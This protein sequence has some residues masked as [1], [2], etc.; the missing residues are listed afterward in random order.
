[1]I[2]NK[3]LA[4]FLMI[5]LL[6]SFIGVSS[7]SAEEPALL[8][9]MDLSK[10]EKGAAGESWGIKNKGVA[11][12]TLVIKANDG[13][14]DA[15][16]QTGTITKESYTNAKGKTVDYLLFDQQ[17]T[18]SG[19]YT[20][21]PN[22]N[23]R[24]WIEDTAWAERE[25]TAEVWMKANTPANENASALFRVFGDEAD[26]NDDRSTFSNAYYTALRAKT[27]S[28]MILAI[29]PYSVNGQT[30][31]TTNT[32]TF[33]NGEW[34]HITIK[35]E[36]HSKGNLQPTILVNGE[37]L[38]NT[39]YYAKDKVEV[40]SGLFFGETSNTSVKGSPDDMGIASIKIYDGILT[41]TQIKEHYDEEKVDYILLQ[42]ETEVCVDGESVVIDVSNYAKDEAASGT[43]TGLLMLGEEELSAELIYDAD[44]KS[45]TINSSDYLLSGK[46][47]ILFAEDVIGQGALK[48]HT[49]LSTVKTEGAAYSNG[50]IS[51]TITGDGTQRSFKVIAVGYDANEALLPGAEFEDITLSSS[52]PET[53]KLA[54]PE[55]MGAKKIKFLIWEICEGFTRPI[56][57]VTEIIVS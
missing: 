29:Y 18:D 11:S 31:Y 38:I 30:L 45:L 51:Y 52:S 2:K 27:D 49:K 12:E 43:V 40:V 36:Y 57:E 53:K 46:E 5:S 15:G 48:L 41:N 9:D 28:S 56:S 19:A 54:V 10:F 34:L 33:A 13:L 26:E 3:S 32:N 7:A 37:K 1:M 22:L 6:L 24:L 16:T 4:L 47:Y 50:E 17:K 44:N 20:E 39:Q 25:F 21:T 23:N 14:T 42:G 8:F 35:K 55:L